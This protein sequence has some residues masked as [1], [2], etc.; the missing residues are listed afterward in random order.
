MRIVLALLLAA[1]V[2]LQV[3]GRDLLQCWWM[4]SVL[5]FWRYDVCVS[6]SHHPIVRGHHCEEVTI[7]CP[8]LALAGADPAELEDMEDMREMRDYLASL[9][10]LRDRYQLQHA[11]QGTM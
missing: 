3:E 4:L 8:G 7:S 9:D 2:M 5:R 1:V 11:A 6:P 10:M